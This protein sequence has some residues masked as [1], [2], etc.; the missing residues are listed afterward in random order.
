[1]PQGVAS[2]SRRETGANV[3]DTEI[4]QLKAESL[5]SIGTQVETAVA[6]LKAFDAAG[7]PDPARRAALLDAAAEKAWAFMIQRELCGLRHWDA[8]VKAYGIPRE[9]LNRMGRVK[10]G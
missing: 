7:A 1:M 8:V 6:R 5:G 4:A 10:T 9:V 2:S 3:L